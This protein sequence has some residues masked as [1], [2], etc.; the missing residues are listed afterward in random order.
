MSLDNKSMENDYVKKSN[1]DALMKL[2]NSIKE[3]N[4]L[5]KVK[6]DESNNKN[7]KKY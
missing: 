1:E 7:S 5:L 2:N 4:F 3:L 6:K